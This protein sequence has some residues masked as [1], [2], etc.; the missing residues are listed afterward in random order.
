MIESLIMETKLQLIPMRGAKQKS[1]HV[2]VD[3]FR[4]KSYVSL[5]R[6]LDIKN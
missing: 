1:I 6:L 4:Y 3:F 2:R 5:D